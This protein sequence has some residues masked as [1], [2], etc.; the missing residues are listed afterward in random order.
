MHT[1]TMKWDVGNLYDENTK[2]KTRE[3]YRYK[4]FFIKSMDPNL[5]LAYVET[6]CILLGLISLYLEV[7]TTSDNS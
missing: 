6:Q 1:E 3:M 7:T 5:L 2:M 4:I